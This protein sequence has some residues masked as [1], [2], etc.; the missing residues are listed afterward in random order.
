G[1]GNSITGDAGVIGS[2]GYMAPEQVEGRVRI[3]AAADI[4]ALGV[5]MFEMVTGR[6]PFVGETPLAS[7]TMRLREPPPSPRKWVADLPEQWERPIRRCLEVDPARRFGQVA[8]VAAALGGARRA[9]RRAPALLALA[10][11][12]VLAAGLAVWA[13][14]RGA[15]AV[16]PEAGG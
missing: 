1:G 13:S 14:R 11:A 16:A 9:R 12:V 8:E 15:P 3:G 4:Y 10:C 5:V 7:M 2:P 6:L